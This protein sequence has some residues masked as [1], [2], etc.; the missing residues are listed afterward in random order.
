MKAMVAEGLEDLEPTPQGP[1]RT[2]TWDVFACAWSIMMVNTGTFSAGAAT[3]SFD[4]SVPETLAGQAAGALVLV[5]GLSLNA[6][7]GVKYGIPFPVLARS[8]FGSGGAHFCTL[9]RGAVATMWLSFQCWQGALG[10]YAA[11]VRCVGK[12]AI[13][14]WGKLDANFHAVKL[15]IFV[16]YL[17]MHA[18]F[19]QLGFQKVKCAIYWALPGATKVAFGSAVWQLPTIFGYWHPVLSVL[20]ALVLAIG[21]MVV[22]I[23]A[24]IPSPINDIMNLAPKRFTHRGC[25]IFVLLLSFAVCPWWTFSGEVSFVFSFLDGY[26]MVTGAIA[27]VFLCDY[28]IV[29][30]R[31]LDLEE[32]YSSTGI[33]WRP[34]V[35]VAVGI[36]PCFPGF[37]DA[38][39]AAH[40]ESH[41]SLVGPFWTHLYSGGSFLVSLV[42]SALAYFHGDDMYSVDLDNPD[43]KS[44]LLSFWLGRMP[45]VKC[46]LLQCEGGC[47][48]GVDP[49]VAISAFS[50]R[51]PTAASTTV[52]S[53][54]RTQEG[55]LPEMP[56]PKTPL[57][58]E[59]IQVVAYLLNLA[60]DV[61]AGDGEGHLPIH[62][63]A[64]SGNV[65][66]RRS[67]QRCCCV[68]GDSTKR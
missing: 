5:L 42:V 50:S 12:E 68:D 23:L 20:G 61:H 60:A 63:A 39:L 47:E 55:F 11:L 28:W 16:A 13:E 48:H 25:G 10:L 19:I 45:E 35:A 31:F 57:P 38:T 51:P 62:V 53:L 32:L 46:D 21:T 36:A 49:D 58:C 59:Q 29:R 1:A 37:L 54:A 4:L 7:P 17:M 6:A 64:E 41:V 2:W 34:L 26:A 3:L 43:R 33:K 65:G 27:G 22:N 44:A 15:L 40:N 67:P 8:S 14:Y 9:T 56:K 30:E 66:E 18:V 24:N 52:P